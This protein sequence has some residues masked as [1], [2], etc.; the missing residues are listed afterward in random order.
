MSTEE[1]VQAERTSDSLLPQDSEAKIEGE[2]EPEPEVEVEKEPEAKETKVDEQS[3]EGCV[4]HVSNLTRWRPHPILDSYLLRN[5]KT[6][7]LEE[8]FGHFG[9]LKKVE[10]R[11]DPRVKLSKGFAYVEY[12]TPSDA[13]NAQLHMDGGQL[14]GNVLKVSF[15]LVNNRR[16]RSDSE[17]KGLTHFSFRPALTVHSP[18]LKESRQRS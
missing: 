15:V 16:R 12:N 3:S 7:H 18:T 9:S 14:D 4:L 11:I 17:E 5:V 10:L 13:E 1:T 2:P 6:E 8:I